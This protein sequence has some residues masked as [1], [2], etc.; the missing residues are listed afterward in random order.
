MR[1]KYF[2]LITIIFLILT[3]S[4]VLASSTIST[5]A[6]KNHITTA[7]EASF[8]L[9]VTN[10]AEKTQSYRIYALELGWMV[11]PLPRDRTFDLAPGKTKTTTIK[12]RPVED[13][14]PGAYAPTLYIDSYLN[15]DYERNTASLKLYLSP[16][17]PMDYLP[18]V[19]VEIDMDEKIDPNEPLSI[20]LFLDNRNPLDLANTKVKISS[21]IHEFRKEVTVDLPP[22]DKKTVE[23]AITP[24]AFQQPKEYILFFVLEREGQPFKVIEKRIEV[25]SLIPPFSKTVVDEA[26]FL[27][28]FTELTVQNN[29]NVLNKQE[30]KH[31]VGLLGA[32]FASGNIEIR[33]DDGQRYLVW[34]VELAPNESIT[35]NYVINYRIIFYILLV[36]IIIGVFYWAVRSPIVISKKASTTR[37]GSDGTLSQIKITM[38]VR[39]RS[40]KSLKEVVITDLVP[41]I[42]NVERSLELGTLKPNDIKH[43]K[44]GTKVT[45]KLAELDGLEHRMI[46]YKVKA[47]LNI[48]GTFSLPRAEVQYGKRKGKHGKA[49]SNIFRLRN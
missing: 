6:I 17:Q 47:K 7:E 49:Y 26:V 21:D 15:D 32:L 24:N 31:P 8:K 3:A 19:T 10:N 22:L 37:G 45:W 27:K 39:N 16:E 48:L 2:T 35:L 34:E 18:A 5:S 40:R 11:E 38:E 23:F 30:V 36:I 13:F 20:K 33:S 29:G 43:T 1:W 14:N 41:A 4:S 28:V 25:L 46:T 44:R 12:V 42:A 9:S